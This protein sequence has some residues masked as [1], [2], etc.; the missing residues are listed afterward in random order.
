MDEVKSH[1]VIS[2]GLTWSSF[3]THKVCS[4]GDMCCER[5]IVEDTGHADGDVEKDVVVEDEDNHHNEGSE[6]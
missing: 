5:Y 4:G 1:Y 2:K 6:P 3:K